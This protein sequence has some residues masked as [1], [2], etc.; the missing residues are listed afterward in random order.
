MREVISVIDFLTA[1]AYAWVEWLHSPRSLASIAFL[2]SILLIDVARRG[3]RLSWSRR[4]VEGILAT[5]SIFHFNFILIPIVWLGSEQVKELYALIGIPSIPTAVWLSIPSWLLAIVA[6]F[7]YDFA[8]YWNHRLMH[9]PW[10]WPVHAIHHSDPDVTGLTAYRVH[11]FEGLVMWVSYTLLLSWLGLPK[12]AIGMGAILIALHNIYVHTNVDWEHGPFRLL[13]ASP[14][15]HRWHHA[16]VKEAY[17][18]NLANICPLFDWMFGTYRVPGKCEER[19][20]AKGVPENDV[21]KLIAW[22]V[23]EWGRMIYAGGKTLAA[24]I[25]PAKSAPSAVNAGEGKL[26]MVARDQITR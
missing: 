13:I 5:I 24:R 6:A 4:A 14:R 2:C 8:N 12:D 22:P 9:Q 20:G 10:L 21:L 23:Q 18:K 19:M 15:F 16:D 11:V 17:G 7:A 3:W 26:T 25:A 1:R